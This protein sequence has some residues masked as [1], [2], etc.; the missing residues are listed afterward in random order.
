M[1]E[2]TLSVR[3]VTYAMKAQSVLERYRIPCRIIRDHKVQKGCGY[4]IVVRGDLQRIQ[5]TLAPHGIQT[6]KESGS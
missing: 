2:H 6:R 5:S 1:E 3:S 4:K